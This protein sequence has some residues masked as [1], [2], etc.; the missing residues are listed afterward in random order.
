M[1]K[2]KVRL[3]CTFFGL[4]FK[5]A[6]RFVC[7]LEISGCG[8]RGAYGQNNW[9]RDGGAEPTEARVGRKIV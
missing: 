6:H 3:V 1:G 5:F 4:L 2:R 9:G 8:A 7:I